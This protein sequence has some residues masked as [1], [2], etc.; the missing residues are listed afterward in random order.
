MSEADSRDARPDEPDRHVLLL[1]RFF[2]EHPAWVA[3]AE[4]I[5]DGANSKVF[6]R[7]RPG[8]EWHLLRRE[9]HSEL[10][11][12][13]A[14][15]PD[16]AFRF[17]PRSIERLAAVEGGIADFAIELFTLITEMDEEARV[18]FR[19]VAPFRRLVRRGYLRLL[20]ESGPRVAAWGSQ[21]GV[22]SLRE[23]RRFVSRMRGGARDWERTG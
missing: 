21:R 7:H 8:D 13:P 5:S 1:A 6:F 19:I 17:T 2:T 11:P 16:F 12:G 23:L 14:P 4:R 20:V 10:L 9:G 18:D 22:G 3:A 15:D